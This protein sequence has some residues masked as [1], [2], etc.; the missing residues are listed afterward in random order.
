VLKKFARSALSLAGIEIRRPPGPFTYSEDGLYSVHNCDFL[1]DRRFARAYQHGRELTTGQDT[2]QGPWR[3]HVAIWAAEKAM[4]RPRGDFIECG[5]WFGFVSSVVMTYLDWNHK[6]GERRFIL[7]DSFQGLATDL[8]TTEEKNSKP[9]KSYGAKYAGT[10]ER[11]QQTMAEFEGVDF[12]KGYVPQVLSDVPTEAVAYLHLDMNSAI[13]EAAALHFFWNKLVPGAAVVFD[14]YGYVGYLPQRIALDK[15][16][17][18][19]GSTILS[20]PTGQG[21]LIK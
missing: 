4:Q 6:R 15:A 17:N 18:D 19:L 10:L 14:D 1:H 2:Y 13:P 8:L 12:V 16:A 11:A 5:V 7:V 20:L 21:L 9:F 3:V